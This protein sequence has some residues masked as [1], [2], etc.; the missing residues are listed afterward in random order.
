MGKGGRELLGTPSLLLIRLPDSVKEDSGESIINSKEGI[1]G[2]GWD[3]AGDR[4]RAMGRSPRGR[5]GNLE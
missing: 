2:V 4:D 5:L 3:T 1:K